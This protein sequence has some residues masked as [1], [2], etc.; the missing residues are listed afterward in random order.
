MSNYQV[1]ASGLYLHRAVANPY[2]VRK[3][4]GLRNH[5]LIEPESAQVMP[6]AD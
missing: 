1:A 2:G 5:N 6:A 3:E 4:L